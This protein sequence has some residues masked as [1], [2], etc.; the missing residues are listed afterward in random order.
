MIVT[1]VSWI[2]IGISALLWGFAALSLLKKIEQ[3]K[4]LSI[5]LVLVLGLAAL[6]VYSEVYS[7]FAGVNLMANAVVLVADIII[8]VIMR[9]A[10]ILQIKEW[11]KDAGLARIIAISLIGMLV[12][13]LSAMVVTNGD[14]YLYHQQA[15]HWIYEYGVVKGL[16]NLHTRFAFNSAFLCLQTLFSVPFAV[17]GMSLHS[18]NGFIV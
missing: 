12:C 2:W 4:Y 15:I 10:V 5:Y 11:I 14:S 13:L 9:R 18:L 1:A 3:S 7:L 8:A 16:G 17:N 6:T